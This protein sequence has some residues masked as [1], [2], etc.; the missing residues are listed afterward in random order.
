ME[1][2]NYLSYGAKHCEFLHMP[3][4]PIAKKV[5]KEC[6]QVQ[7]DEQ[8]L[9]QTWDHTLD[10]SDSLALEVYQAGATPFVNLTTQNSFLNY[11]TSVP[12][13]YYG[14]TPQAFLS[15]LDQIDAQVVLFGPKDPK[16]LKMAPGE[17]F[18]KAFESEKPVMEKLR[19]KKSGPPTFPWATSLQNAL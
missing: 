5:I 16:V 15:L 19:E 8:V 7:E 11:L 10:I 17:R 14:K 4:I 13:K 1:I 18:S 6:L 12:E 9:I 2:V 3:N